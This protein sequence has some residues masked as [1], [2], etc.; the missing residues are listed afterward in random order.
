M[1]VMAIDL[2]NQS[3]ANYLNELAE[4]L[5]IGQAQVNAIHAQLG[6]PA[7]YA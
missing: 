6:V 1:S 4:G 7:L 2:D 3:E 5:G